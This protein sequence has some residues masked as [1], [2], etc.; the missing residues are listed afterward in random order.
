[1][2]D[3]PLIPLNK[4]VKY[5]DQGT[6]DVIRSIVKNNGQLKSAEPKLEYTIEYINGLKR[7]TVSNGSGE[8]VYLWKKLTY[9]ISPYIKHMAAPP[10]GKMY[11][12]TPEQSGKLDQLALIICNNIP[13]DLHYGPRTRGETL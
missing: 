12:L 8:K 4:V 6:L 13:K 10:Y 1:M 9:V 11:G 2:P 5:L 7:K 3:M